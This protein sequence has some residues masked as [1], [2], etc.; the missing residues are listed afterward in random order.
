MAETGFYSRNAAIAAL[1]VKQARKHDHI[2]THPPACALS[3]SYGLTG[4]LFVFV[5]LSLSSA[6][7]KKKDGAV[8]AGQ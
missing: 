4:V 6:P 5:Y 1:F 7:I 2:Y 8:E 3:L